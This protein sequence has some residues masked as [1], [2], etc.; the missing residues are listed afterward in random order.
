MFNNPSPPQGNQRDHCAF[1]VIF[2]ATCPLPHPCL[3]FL[4]IFQEFKRHLQ[5]KLPGGRCLR[6]ATNQLIGESHE[7][8][9][10]REIRGE[11]GLIV[12]SGT[13]ETVVVESR[14]SFDR[15]FFSV[16]FNRCLGH[17]RTCPMQPGDP[18]FDIEMRD[19][20]KWKTLEE[21]LRGLHPS[22]LE[23]FIELLHALARKNALIRQAIDEKCHLPG[24]FR[25]ES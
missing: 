2:R 6:D 4:V 19:I 14:K 12:P 11:V 18:E 21:M 9:M 8:T 7:Q 3:E 23:M 20:P 24:L 13:S 10:C 5:M 22:H 15:V 16:E 25:L 17:L 1:A